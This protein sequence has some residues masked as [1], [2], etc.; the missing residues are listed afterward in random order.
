MSYKDVVK[1]ALNNFSN[2][3][4]EPLTGMS[5]FIQPVLGSILG[6]FAELDMLIYKISKN[7]ENL[8]DLI[9][10]VNLDLNITPTDQSFMLMQIAECSAGINNGG[11]NTLNSAMDAYNDGI[12]KIN[13]LVS[14]AED[15]INNKLN[16]AKNLLTDSNP[17]NKIDS[18]KA[19]VEKL[20]NNKIKLLGN[21]SVIDCIQMIAALAACCDA[22]TGAAKKVADLTKKFFYYTDKDGKYVP[23]NNRVEKADYDMAIFNNASS[24]FTSTADNIKNKIRSFI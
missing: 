3:I 8:I 20:L 10:N 18:L 16:T 19:K 4:C 21:K 17:F 23:D 14:D 6:I 5:M 13:N 9:P 1:N 2:S 15:W 22:L 24:K 12:T 11:I 7:Y